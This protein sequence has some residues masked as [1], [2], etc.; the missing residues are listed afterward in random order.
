MCVSLSTVRFYCHCL[1]VEESE[2]PWCVDSGA[3]ATRAMLGASVDQIF[4]SRGPIILPNGA[5]FFFCGQ[6]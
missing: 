5:R 6:L 3:A 2:A 1:T 4:F